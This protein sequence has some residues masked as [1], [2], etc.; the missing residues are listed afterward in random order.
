MIARAACQVD[1]LRGGRCTRLT[2]PCL[3]AQEAA[4]H[5]AVATP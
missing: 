4:R 3:P 2:F 5:D 1:V